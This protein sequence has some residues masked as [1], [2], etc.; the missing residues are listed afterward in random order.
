[1]CCN[2]QSAMFIC[3]NG[4]EGWRTGPWIIGTLE[5]SAQA[6]LLKRERIM[7]VEIAKVLKK[8]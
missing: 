8:S 2:A 6:V 4:Q 3:A 1:M 7:A 5:S